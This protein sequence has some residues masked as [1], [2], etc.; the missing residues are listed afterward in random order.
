VEEP[1]QP[2]NYE[3]DEPA[4][5]AEV[6]TT[7]S[8]QANSDVS[9]KPQSLL[10]LQREGKPL[11]KKQKALLHAAA[12]SRTPLPSLEAQTPP[13]AEKERREATESEATP[14]STEEE[15]K[16][17]QNRVWNLVKGKWF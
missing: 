10:T 11:S 8:S 13:E 14:G 17:I 6:Q 15:K 16:E 5:S 4:S 9:A 12:I 3:F 7:A 1:H 2:F